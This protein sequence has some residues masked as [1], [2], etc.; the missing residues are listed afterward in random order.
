LSNESVLVIDDEEA[1][2]RFLRVALEGQSFQVT[3]AATGKDGIAI[4]MA[5]NLM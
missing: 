1:I 2:R 4:T 3:E 5:Q